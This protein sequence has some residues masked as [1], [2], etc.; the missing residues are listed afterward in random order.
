MTRERFKELHRTARLQKLGTL[1]FTA[2]E[3]YDWFLTEVFDLRI[4]KAYLSVPRSF[5]V[6]AWS[7]ANRLAWKRQRDYASQICLCSRCKGYHHRGRDCYQ[8]R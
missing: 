6:L 8:H 1:A 4:G 2:G 5:D 7:T 3:W